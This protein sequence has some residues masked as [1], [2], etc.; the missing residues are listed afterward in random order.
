MFVFV[1]SYLDFSLPYYVNY[2]LEFLG[3]KHSGRQA[4]IK[5]KE[6]EDKNELWAHIGHKFVVKHKLI[7]DM[8][9]ISILTQGGMQLPLF[10]QRLCQ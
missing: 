5:I 7:L 10:T 6:P 1:S 9:T 3:D 8:W 4:Q 2:P